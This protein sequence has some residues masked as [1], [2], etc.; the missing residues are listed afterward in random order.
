MS[1]ASYAPSTSKQLQDEVYRFVV[2]YLQA[3]GGR[4]PTIRE[5]GKALS[6]TSTSHVQYV[7]TGLERRGMITRQP[8]KSRGIVLDGR[9]AVMA[10]VVTETER[11]LHLRV[12][13]D[14]RAFRGRLYLETE[15]NG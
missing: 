3:N 13:R 12:V 7:L 6:I 15:N 4:P 10:E 1:I 5:I 2:E 11:S 9:Q 8:N 14:G